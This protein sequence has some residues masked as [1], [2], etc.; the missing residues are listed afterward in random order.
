MHVVDSCGWLE[1]FANG[2]LAEKYAE[3]LQAGEKLLVPVVVLYEVYKILKREIGEAKA[4][5]ATGQWFM[6]LLLHTVAL[7][8]LRIQILKGFPWYTIFRKSGRLSDLA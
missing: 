4:L 5:L 7:F 6:L 1:W 3:H 2:S 8:I